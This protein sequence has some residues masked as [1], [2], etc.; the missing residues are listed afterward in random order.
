LLRQ[1]VAKNRRI[2]IED[3]D[4]RHGRKSRSQKFDGFKRHVAKDLDSEII[5]AV[6]ITSA[7]APE[8]SHN[9]RF[10]ILDFGLFLSI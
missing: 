9:F 4:M 8:A 2:S 3:E 5:R 1:G 6:G 7:N 10:W